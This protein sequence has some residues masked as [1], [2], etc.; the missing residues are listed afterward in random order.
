M[1]D[2]KQ[3]LVTDINDESAHKTP[4]RVVITPKSSRVDTNELMSHL[5]ATT[6]LEKTVRV[7]MNVIG[8]DGKP[9]IYD[10]KAL[11]LEWL[12]FRFQTVRKRLEFRL[13]EVESRLHILEG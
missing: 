10:L 6:D 1:K 5:F 2:K 4:I 13:N 8:M 11:L 7:N 3:P 12:T 9:K